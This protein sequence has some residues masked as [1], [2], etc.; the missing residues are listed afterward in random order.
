MVFSLM[1][2]FWLLVIGVWITPD[3]IEVWEAALTLA[4]IPLLVI[5]S[6]MAENDFFGIFYRCKTA[7]V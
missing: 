5:L 6:W 4:F 2:Y 7:K 1:A 3:I